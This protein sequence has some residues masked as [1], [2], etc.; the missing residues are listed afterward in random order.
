MSTSITT[1]TVDGVDL[2][3]EREI[4]APAATLY[5][6]WT[7]PTL[8][9][10]WFCPRPWGVARANMDV[11]PGGA[12]EIVMRSPEGQEF[13]NPGIYLD[14]VPNRRLVFTDAF[15]SA[16]VPSG[17]AFMVGEIDFHDLGNGRTRYRARARHW[18]VADREAHERMGFREGWTIATQQLADLAATL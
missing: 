10:L 5:R 15:T 8:L 18:S 3:L 12:S 17:K 9:P 7:D 14:V 13:P 4:D 2:V 16:W 11:R 1:V 6:C